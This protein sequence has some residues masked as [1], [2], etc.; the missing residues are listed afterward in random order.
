MPAPHSELSAELMD[1]VMLVLPPAP[2]VRLV[3]KVE[4]VSQFEVFVT[5]QNRGMVSVLVNV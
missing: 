4:M 3:A 1:A 2:S 5:L